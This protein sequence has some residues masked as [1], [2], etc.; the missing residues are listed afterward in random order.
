MKSIL[1]LLLLGVAPTAQA[2]EIGTGAT[3]CSNEGGN[4][5]FSGTKVV[6]Y[7]SGSKYTSK[8][9]SG[10]AACNT[11]T[12]G[13]DPYPNWGKMCFIS[14]EAVPAPAPVVD[15]GTDA[16]W[17]ANEGGNCSFTGAR[18]VRYGS[19]TRTITKTLTGGTPCT[20]A[21]FGSD[22]YPNFGKMCFL[23]KS[24]VVAPA[25]APAPAPVVDIGANAS[26]C[27][28]EGANCAFTGTR[29]VRYGSGNRTITK[30]LTGGTACSNAAF[31]SDPYP[32]QGKM[33][34][35]VKE[36]VVAPAPAPVV[37]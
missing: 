35:L 8:T 10:G 9:L 11:A 32:Y 25:P 23:V 14:A 5:S 21:A 2:A 7:G 31:G 36:A 16:T 12:F 17:C 15:I 37:D 19:G 34:F 4:C 22:P 6:R 3:W 29:E 28:N 30:T 24:S 33:C 18:E 26:W 13:V 27:A 20:T 1:L